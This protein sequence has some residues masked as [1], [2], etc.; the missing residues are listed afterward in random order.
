[1]RDAVGMASLLV[2]SG[3]PGAGKSTLSATLAS[4]LDP[5]VLVEGDQF[6]AFLAEGAIEPWL[7]ESNAQNAVVAEAAAAAT[8]RFAASYETVYDGVLGPWQLA[9]F[10]AA[11]GLSE[12]DYVIVL[13][14]VEVCLSRVLSR[15]GHGFTDEAATRHMHAQFD[16]ASIDPRHLMCDLATGVEDTVDELISRQ[17]AGQ[18]LYQVER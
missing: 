15:N 13:P 5:S 1:M 7:P 2:V 12:F 9:A 16:A 4:R 11:T 3:P 10:A 8:G 17:A 14:D 18:F 6:F